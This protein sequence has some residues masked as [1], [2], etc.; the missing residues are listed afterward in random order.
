MTAITTPFSGGCAC[1]AIRYESTSQPVMMLHCHC[2]DCQ[3]SS[4]GPFSSFVIVPTEA[5]KLLQGSLRFHASPSEAGGKTH[6]GF[7][8]DCGSTMFWGHPIRVDQ[9]GIPVGAFADPSFPQ[10][11]VSIFMPYKH[12]WV[13]VPEGVPTYEGHSPRMA[14]PGESKSLASATRRK[15]R[16]KIRVMAANAP[17]SVPIPR[18]M[19]SC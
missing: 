19:R 9:I 2:R 3:R 18:A 13:V 12:P 6:R 7:C 10:P 1:G 15:R 5:F 14:Q 4:G 11:E 8:P 17:D 16:V